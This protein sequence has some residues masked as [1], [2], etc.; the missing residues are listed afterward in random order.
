MR[1]N[2]STG[3]LG[4]TRRL[5]CATA[6]LVLLGG[7]LAGCGAGEDDP[8]AAGGA[9]PLDGS[10]RPSAV[11]EDFV[12]TPHGWFHASCVVEV[13]EG[14]TVGEDGALLRADGTARK[15]GACQHPRY[16]KLGGRVGERAASAPPA[17]VVN[18]WVASVSSTSL[19]PVQSISASWRVPASPPAR[20]QT[21][22]FFPAL[23][24]AATG[25][26]IL[27]PV[28]AWNGFADQRWTIAGWNCCTAGTVLHSAPRR[29][30][31][32]D[33]IT[34]SVTGSQCDAAGVCASW[35]VRAASSRGAATTLTTSSHGAALDWEFGGA[36]EAYNLDACDQYPPDGRITFGSIVVRR[37]GGAAATPAWVPMAYG[38]PPD[39]LT[40]VAA[41]PGGASVTLSWR[42][43]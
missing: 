26:L 43:R 37:A 27:Q 31:P 39:C 15:V 34:G 19:G 17:A 38:P 25:A 42:T 11:P 6:A 16:D 14:E 9:A 35:S 32:G 21:L 30:Q 36:L 40:G 20:G 2:G 12:A 24:P 10:A 18:G 28:L 41:A 29:V 13:E 7:V 1:R 22:Y 23:E 33:R 3:P 4:G 8:A 5:G